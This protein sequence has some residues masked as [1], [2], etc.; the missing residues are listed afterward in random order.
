MTKFLTAFILIV[1]IASCT[2]NTSKDLANSDL[3]LISS[4]AD[5]VSA[6]PF[7][8]T[9]KNG[10]VYL[11]WIEK[12]ADS[13]FFKFSIL[14][15]DEWSTA[16]VITS[17][18]DWFVN[19]ADY[20]MLVSDGS[21][22]LM[23]HYLE[24]SAKGTFTYDVK[25]ITSNDNGNTWSLPLI[26]H[27]DGKKAEHGFVSMQPDNNKYFASWLDG[28]NT[29]KEGVQSGHNTGHHGEMS[30]RGAELDKKGKKINEWELDKKVCDC[31]QTS[32]AITTNGPV[33]VYRDRSDEEIRDMSIVRM[34]DG[35]WTDPQIIYAD[36]WKIPGCPVNGPQVAAIGNNLAI[37]WF[38]SP[39][40]NSQVKI[41][42]S[43]NGGK[44]FHKPIRIDKDSTI[45]RVDLVML[46]SKNA[47]ISWM[48]GSKIKVTKV[49][50]DGTV[51]EPI[52]VA[53]TSVSR[54]S[55]FPQ[56]IKSGNKLV[57]AWTDSEAKSIKVASI[58]LSSKN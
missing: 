41:I 21:G 57:F 58:P 55:G 45:G 42:F 2:S 22:N 26:L 43:E 38:S 46:D 52:V 10:S 37:A 40:R 3:K 35:K 51:D 7:L 54:S 50:M 16:K 5:S 44:S 48:E 33:V 24:K 4:P 17:G 30:L 25:L 20:P 18:V 15:N 6:E 47:A 27:D 53:S 8:F 49:S 9:D 13:N 1:S 36:N 39:E 14:T 19:W 56:M 11:S 32:A 23:A 28:R 31:C 29:V 12:R 34:V